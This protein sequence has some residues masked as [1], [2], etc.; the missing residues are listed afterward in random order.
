M[1]MMLYSSST[2]IDDDNS[3]DILKGGKGYYDT[4]HAGDKDIIED[5]DGKGEVYFNN[6]QLIGGI[7]DKDKSSNSIKVY[8]SEDK[9]I[10]KQQSPKS[11]W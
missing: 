11:N 9:N 3:S 7:L 5:S 1:G 6:T 10:G 4:Y 2:A 8:L